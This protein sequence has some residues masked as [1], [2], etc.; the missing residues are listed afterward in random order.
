V[1]VELKRKVPHLLV[2]PY[3]SFVTGN[4]IWLSSQ[5]PSC[6]LPPS[7]LPASLAPLLSFSFCIRSF[8][9][10]SG[11]PRKWADLDC[12]FFPTKEQ[13]S[14][15]YLFDEN[16]NF[17]DR[18]PSSEGIRIS[19]ICFVRFRLN[20]LASLMTPAF[21]ETNDWYSEL[22][23]SIVSFGMLSMSLALSAYSSSFSFRWSMMSTAIFIFSGSL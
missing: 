11:H 8:R 20:S 2:G 19:S 23:Y 17:V 1:C 9:F 12:W 10:R 16:E 3:S 4:V 22:M 21:A 18:Y 14:H 7:S 5:F 15:L 13:Y 6:A